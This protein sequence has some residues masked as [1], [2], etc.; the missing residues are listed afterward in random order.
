MTKKIKVTKKFKIVVT[1][2]GNE[3]VSVDLEPW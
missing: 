3:V 1:K 2:I